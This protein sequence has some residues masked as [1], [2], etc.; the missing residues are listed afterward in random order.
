MTTTVKNIWV[1]IA[2]AAAVLAA[3][4]AFPA[5]AVQA[6]DTEVRIDNFAFAPQRTAVK[7]G[8]TVT[9][10]NEDD[11]PHAVVSSGKFFK[12]KALDTEDKFSFTFTTA[13]TYEYFC[14][15]H[16]HMTGTIVVEAATGSIATQ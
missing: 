16:P 2:L 5:V 6:A 10:I 8:T 4:A 14:S 13:G 15:L 9:W 12:S 1:A 7:A 3:A 11:T